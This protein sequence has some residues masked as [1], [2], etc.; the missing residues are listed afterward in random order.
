MITICDNTSKV[1]IDVIGTEYI[2]IL[3]TP[4]EDYLMS[5]AVLIKS[6][7]DNR[8]GRKLD[9]VIFYKNI[10]NKK[11]AEID[12]MYSSVDSIS[13]RFYNIEKVIGELKCFSTKIKPRIATTYFR[14]L[15][16]YYM[17]KYTKVL[18]IDPDVVVDGDFT[19]LYETELNNEFVAAVPDYI[20]TWEL[21]V[22]DDLRK[23]RE[24]KLGIVPENYFNAGI[25]LLNTRLFREKYSLHD[26]DDIMSKK[27]TSRDQDILNYICGEKNKK[28][29]DYKYNYIHYMQDERR[30]DLIKAEIKK[31]IDEGG[32]CPVLIHYA[33][34]LKPWYDLNAPYGD[35]FW[36]YAEKTKLYT[37]LLEEVG[38]N[39]AYEW[40]LE[41]A[42]ER[43]IGV[44]RILK[45]MKAYLFSK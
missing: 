1:K 35:L 23:Y 15:A 27:W 19:E 5:A 43:R 18:Y 28:L 39:K 14:L 41:M 11:I 3:I 25:L 32:E 34:P 21:S 12:D 44:T 24:G 6:L 45:I 9:I 20:S 8:N 30:N 13:L 4:H 22:N 17:E 31:I 36:K 10:E 29:V 33:G 42:R 26:M 40:T 7:I 38:K 37:K 16:P 2:P